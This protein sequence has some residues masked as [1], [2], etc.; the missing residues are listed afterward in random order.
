MILIVKFMLDLLGE[1]IAKFNNDIYSFLIRFLTSLW[2]LTPL[3]G[4]TPGDQS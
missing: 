2:Y 4:G 1:K 3:S